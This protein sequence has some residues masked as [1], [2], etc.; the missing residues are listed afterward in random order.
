M[1]DGTAGDPTGANVA[2]GATANPATGVDPASLLGSAGPGGAGTAPG[3]GN[4]VQAP[5]TVV[6]PYEFQYLEADTVILGSWMA[7]MLGLPASQA[8]TPINAATVLQ[9]YNELPAAKQSA[10]LTFL[11]KAGFYVDSDGEVPTTQPDINASDALNQN[12]MANALLVSYNKNLNASPTGTTVSSLTASLIAS[13]AGQQELQ[14]APAPITGGANAYQVMLTSPADLYNTLYTTYE[15]ALGQ[16]PTQ[17]Q[18][19]KFVT[20]F[21]GEQ[22][23]YQAALNAQ[24]EQTSY[25]QFLMKEQARNTQLGYARTP[26]VAG[27][28]VP[29]GPFSTASAWASA[30]NAYLQGALGI[31]DTASNTAY[32][33]SIINKLGTWGQSGF[34]PLGVQVPYPGPAQVE[35]GR[36]NLNAPAKYSSTAVGMQATLDELANYP[37]L[38]ELLMSG[39][40]SSAKVQA[41]YNQGTLPPGPELAQFTNNKI[42]APVIPTVAETDAANHAHAVKARQAAP[43]AARAAPAARPAPTVP[44]GYGQTPAQADA[45]ARAALAAQQKAA[46]AAQAA[47]LA[48]RATLPQNAIASAALAR[49]QAGRGPAPATAPVPAGIAPPVTPRAPAAPT[50]AAATPV[51]ATPAERNVIDEPTIAEAKAKAAQAKAEGRAGTLPLPN[52]GLATTPAAN[53]TTG[54]DQYSTGDIYLGANTLVGTQ[55]PSASALAFTQATTGA[56]AVPYQVNQY[57]NAFDTIASMIASGQAA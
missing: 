50:T 23:K 41:Q 14:T 57:L 16:A 20:V 36:P 2:P 27:G 48:P 49:G 46:T 24:Q 28:P 44:T 1:S 30:F 52:M 51:P 3:G 26:Q 18:L 47:A 42:K 38:I 37:G 11:W 9:D 45:I 55:P 43:V 4:Q 25:N 8:A 21:Q 53:L 54:Q 6:S 40:A 31:P 17:S 32:I 34:N 39:N 13:G 12:A 29:T 19:D 22:S 35:T 10:L 5:A 7:S 56:N 33:L 15:S